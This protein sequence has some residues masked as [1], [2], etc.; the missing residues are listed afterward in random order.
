MHPN[1]KIFFIK[2][3]KSKIIIL[4]LFSLLLVFSKTLILASPLLL[5]FIVDSISNPNNI[6]IN[7]EIILIIYVLCMFL[8]HALNDYKEY[9]TELI[10]QPI[11]AK[12]SKRVFNGLINKPISFFV[13]ASSGKSIKDICRALGSLQTVSA[14]TLHTAL[15][16]L[17][18]YLI[19]L[20]AISYTNGIETFIVLLITLIAHAC[21]TLY[22]I[23]EYAISRTKLNDIDSD[24]A[25]KI[26]ELHFNFETVKS[27]GSEALE[28][29]KFSKLANDYSTEAMYFQKMSSKIAIIQQLIIHTGLAFIFVNSG[30]KS[31]NGVNTAGDFIF[32]ITLCIQIFGPIGFLGSAWKD[33]KKAIEDV[34]NI[35]TYL[36]N[37]HIINNET[38]LNDDATYANAFISVENLS[39][40]YDKSKCTLNNLNFSFAPHSLNVVCGSSGSGKSSLLR[41]LTR[42][43]Q[44]TTGNIFINNKNQNQI[45]IEEYRKIV[46]FVA[47]ETYLIKGSII[48]N[49][50]YGNKDATFDEVIDCTKSVQ[51][52]DFIAALPKGYDTE[53]NERSLNLSGGQK[54]RISIARALLNK[55]RILVLDEPASSLDY[56][57][58]AEVIGLITKLSK[59]I[60][61]IMTTHRLHSITHADQIIVLKDGILVES[62]NHEKLINL[63]GEYKRLFQSH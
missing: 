14:L 3:Y 30:I 24:L 58:E 44:L 28:T 35:D 11:I 37:V 50:R 56:S 8:S 20:I 46:A 63:S 19:I 57:T 40:S 29:A 61:C 6:Y 4:L 49:L 42:L 7:V 51:L 60:T 15:P 2:E 33:Y 54:Q 52:H 12:V 32:T 27:F 43:Y 31:F 41:L 21:Y 34:K 59:S 13:S 39:F 16:T 5:K 26:S 1:L 45:S 36:E 10:V 47:Q 48:E 9:L 23:N 18:E 38:I 53:I 62:G 22:S 17:I 25:S 55:P